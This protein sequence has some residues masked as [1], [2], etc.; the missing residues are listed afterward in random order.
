MIH[1]CPEA[2]DAS[3][4]ALDRLRSDGDKAHFTPLLR[5]AFNVRDGKL[6]ATALDVAGDGNANPTAREAGF[7]ML[8]YQ[9]TEDR[10]A[11]FDG[12]SRATE[13]SG[14]PL[15]SVDDRGMPTLRSPLPSDAAER[16]DSIASSVADDGHAPELVRVAA[17][18]VAQAIRQNSLWQP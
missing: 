14:C 16:A 10:T 6:F 1:A 17:D 5:V 18:C 4:A 7:I 8:V 12:I 3:A 11:S 2:G 9:L 13:T 15:N